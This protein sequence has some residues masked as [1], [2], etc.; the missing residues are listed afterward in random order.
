MILAVEVLRRPRAADTSAR[1]RDSAGERLAH[2]LSTI[3]G[4]ANNEVVLYLVTGVLL[5]CERSH[6]H[7][8]HWPILGE[9]RRATANYLSESPARAAVY[10]QFLEE[11]LPAWL[12]SEESDKLCEL[13]E[14]VEDGRAACDGCET[15][16]PEDEDAELHDPCD[17]PCDN[18]WE[19]ARDAQFAAAE[20]WGN[21][22][23]DMLN[24]FVAEHPLINTQWLAVH[25]VPPPARAQLGML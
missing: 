17:D 19:R 20:E 8:R 5:R 18:V 12:E 22:L 1:A 3:S 23:H 6:C 10:A 14:Y 24:L 2:A 11:C 16:E 21:E 4:H 15:R 13:S 25:P 7:C 9:S